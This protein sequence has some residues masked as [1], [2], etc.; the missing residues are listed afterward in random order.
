MRSSSFRIGIPD[1][2]QQDWTLTQA[3]NGSIYCKGCNKMVVDFTSFSD[4][5]LVKFI[6][7]PRNAGAC[8]R[9]YTRQLQKNYAVSPPKSKYSPVYLKMILAGLFA[10]KLPATAQ[11]SQTLT[12][13]SVQTLSAVNKQRPSLTF[14][15]GRV[16]DREL[17]KG[18]FA[19]I[20]VL[21]PGNDGQVLVSS[22]SDENGYYYIHLPVTGLGNYF[23][24][25]FLAEQYI[26]R[27][28]VVSRHRNSP[29]LHVSLLPCSVPEEELKEPNAEPLSVVTR[30]E[31]ARVTS[32]VPVSYLEPLIKRGPLNRARYFF[33]R[34][35]HRIGFF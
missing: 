35:L 14:V 33:R 11:Q 19:T 17:K 21:S 25:V 1:P 27:S 4:E 8:G 3:S 18:V 13:A 12:T 10:I 9:F 28:I 20:K 24:L 30:I 32:G 5:A 22:A 31:E 6:S 34:L 29:L 16:F 23:K 7:D 2:C 15:K 26:E